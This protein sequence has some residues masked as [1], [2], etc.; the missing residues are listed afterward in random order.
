MCTAV[1]FPA[2]MA[3]HM[4]GPGPGAAAP[5]HLVL[6]PTGNLAAFI[7]RE[8][9][10]GA[11]DM[12]DAKGTTTAVSGSLV[13]DDKGKVDPAGSKITVILDSLATDKTRRDGYIKRNTLETAEFPTAVL[14]V[15]EIQGLGGKLPQSGN[16]TL[17]LLGDLTVHGVTKPTVWQVTATADKGEFT[18]K[19]V[20]HIHFG[21]FN[22]KQPSVA[23]VLTV[24]DDITLE[25]DFHF[26]PAKG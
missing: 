8:K 6:A 5:V 26:V 23:I 2:L 22:M 13:I 18:G 7:V 20:T 19:A 3:A 10:A 15:K 12:N 11:V 21:D 9:L 14:V 4:P 17:T 1:L 25:Y 16:L 24:V